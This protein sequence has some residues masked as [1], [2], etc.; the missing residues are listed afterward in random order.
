MRGRVRI[1]LGCGIATFLGPP[2]TRRTNGSDAQPPESPRCGEL[3]LPLLGRLC[4][5]VGRLAA[6]SEASLVAEVL[7]LDH[8][9]PAA[10]H[11]WARSHVHDEGSSRRVELAGPTGSNV[12]DSRVLH[13]VQI[14][15]GTPA[16]GDKQPLL[17]MAPAFPQLE[18][19]IHTIG[20]CNSTSVRLRCQLAWRH[21]QLAASDGAAR[22]VGVSQSWRHVAFSA[23]CV[24]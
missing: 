17:T 5:F 18:A 3:S 2:P 10:E 23:G 4:F 16:T 9:K 8:P 22:K 14:L 6:T 13:E 11:A 21:W 7:L 12:L 19:S 24:P 15:V 20:I 1:Q